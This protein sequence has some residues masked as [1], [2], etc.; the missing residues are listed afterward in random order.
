MGSGV[1]GEGVVGEGVV[2]EGGV[3]EGRGTTL[4]EVLGKGRVNS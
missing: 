4:E 3:C 1:V 2:G